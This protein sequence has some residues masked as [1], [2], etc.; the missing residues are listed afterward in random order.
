MAVAKQIVDYYNS[1]ILNL[2]IS[3]S[4]EKIEIP[5][6]KVIKLS[7]C[8]IQLSMNFKMLLRIKISRFS[9]FF[10]RR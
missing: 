2:S 4:G 1:F 9:A 8:S 5:G 7:S 3:S 6:P 10:R